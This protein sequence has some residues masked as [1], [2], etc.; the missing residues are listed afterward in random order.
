MRSRR[1]LVAYFLVAPLLAVGSAGASA[2]GCC[3]CRCGTFYGLAYVPYYHYY[4]RTNHYQPCCGNCCHR[5]RACACSGWDW[6][7]WLAW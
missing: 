5:P 1:L 2:G 4:P 6:H 3:S 7:A